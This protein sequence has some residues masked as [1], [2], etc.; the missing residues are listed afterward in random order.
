MGTDL[1][2]SRRLG[3]GRGDS[4]LALRDRLLLA[5]LIT[6]ATISIRFAEVI[7]ERRA[8]PY[9]KRGERLMRRRLPRTALGVRS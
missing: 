9:P 6:A 5:A 1:C 3:G 7:R 4:E 8:R 2:Y